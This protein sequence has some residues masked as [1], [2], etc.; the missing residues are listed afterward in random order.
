MPGFQYLVI[1]RKLPVCSLQFE[2]SHTSANVDDIKY[3]CAGFPVLVP[4]TVHGNW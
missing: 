3:F 4:G 2:V 1:G